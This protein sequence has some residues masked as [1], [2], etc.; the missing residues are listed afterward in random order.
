MENLDEIKKNAYQLL[1]KKTAK[2]SNDFSKYNLNELLHEIDVYHAELEAQNEEL[3][4]KENY[5]N[6]SSKLNEIL[7]EEAPFSYLCLNEKFHIENANEMARKTLNINIYNKSNNF[8]KFIGKNNLKKFLIWSTGENYV[9]KPLELN[10]LVSKGTKRF[11]LFLKDFKNSSGWYLLSLLDIDEEHKLNQKVEEHNKILYEIAQYQSNILIIFDVNYNLKFVN[12]SFNNFFDVDN[13]D[14]FISKYGCV[15][16]TFLKR[17]NFFYTQCSKIE[18][19]V[20]KM[21]LLDDS[22]RVVTIFDRKLQKEKTFIINISITVNSEYICTFSEITN[23]SLQ[24][25]EFREKSYKDALTQIYNRAKF[26]E[27]LDEYLSFVSDDNLDLISIMFDIDFFKHINDNHGHTIG[28]KILIE[29][30]AL[31]N[32]YIRKTDIFARWGGEEFVVLLKECSIDEAIELAQ[33]IRLAMEEHTFTNNLKVT[34]SFG[35]A[36][37]KKGDTIEDFIKRVDDKLYE[38]KEFSRNCVKW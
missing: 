33:R 12:N 10:L 17:E 7:F 34:A 23:F 9:D 18:N 8:F 36:K 26:N 15:C 4:E 28:D 20:K 27:I 24:K 35:I 16:N 19:W 14:D 1:S 32:K 6:E 5:L 11:R 29:V 3:L 37:V 13:I 38:A 31:A 30:S 22:K 25:E 2:T 21:L